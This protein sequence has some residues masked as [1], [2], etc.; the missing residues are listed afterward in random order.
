MP[1]SARQ[2]VTA[3]LA[4][5]AAFALVAAVDIWVDPVKTADAR[6]LS[7]A[8]DFS[9]HTYQYDA[10]GEVAKRVVFFVDPLPLLAILALLCAYAVWRG[11]LV[12][13]AAALTVVA[14]ANL[15]TQVAKHLLAHDRNEPF[16]AHHPDSWTFPS[17]H[18]TA[19]AS[20]IIAAAWVAP[21]EHRR[22]VLAWGAAYVVAVGVATLVLEWHFPSDALGG[23]L[24]ALGWGFGVLAVYLSLPNRNPPPSERADASFAAGCV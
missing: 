22:A 4:C 14:G 19:A 7:W 16:L 13:A 23:V 21:A 15:T 11:R 24:V 3:A 17:G 1:R 2:A 9:W 6:V 20:L 18:V 8:S 10:A 5:V 12:E